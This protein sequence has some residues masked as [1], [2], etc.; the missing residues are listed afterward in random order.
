MLHCG[1]LIWH[2]RRYSSLAFYEPAAVFFA[3]LTIW[4]YASYTPRKGIAVAKASNED[5][6]IPDYAERPAD[7]HD[8]FGVDQ[9]SAEQSSPLDA[10]PPSGVYNYPAPS[11]IRLDRPNDDEMVQLFVQ[12]GRPSAMTA[13]ISNVGDICSAN[14][15]L[16]MLKEGRNL[17]EQV[18][19]CWVRN[20][21][22]LFMLLGLEQAT[23]SR[24]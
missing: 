24:S 4:A 11:F 14:G 16:R 12:S 17:L 9:A 8:E 22:Y 15:P 20:P 2:I 6:T 7:T 23:M 13:Y 19:R 18:S 5:R 10:P 3:T 1:C 21:D